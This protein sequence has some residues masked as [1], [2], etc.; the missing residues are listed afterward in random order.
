MPNEDFP[1]NSPTAVGAD[2]QATVWTDLRAI[3][4]GNDPTRQRE[5]L[6]RICCVY[7]KPLYAFIR[8]QGN[9]PE[10]A[11]ELTQ[12]FFHH[13]LKRERLKLADQK[14]GR[15]RSFLLKS[16]Q[17]FLISEWDRRCA[18]KRDERLV[19]SLDVPMGD[20]G[21]LA[22]DPASPGEPP[23]LAF[24]LQWARELFAVVRHRLEVELSSPEKAPLLR[25][26]PVAL[27]EESE[28]SYAELGAQLGKSEDAVKK[29]IERLRTRW[30]ALVREEVA[31]TVQSSEDVETELRELLALVSHR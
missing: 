1:W 28:V 2:F 29:A 24:D 31:A 20:E 25:L 14:R 15:F 8:R 30:E 17:R 6:E 26:L 23:D 16:L 4:S 10:V 18:K 7:W 5:A 12:D 3:A 19:V 11:R 22:L 27:R 9:S 21:D 13:L